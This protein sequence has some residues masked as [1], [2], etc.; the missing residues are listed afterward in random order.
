M[1]REACLKQY[2]DKI[3]V[4][5]LLKLSDRFEKK[6]QSPEQ[7][8]VSAV[9]AKITTFTHERAKVTNA[10]RSEYGLPRKESTHVIEADQTQQSQPEETTSEA[11]APELTTGDLDYWKEKLGT[12]YTAKEVISADKTDKS[13]VGGQETEI[14]R[15]TDAMQTVLDAKDQRYVDEGDDLL[16]AVA[17]LADTSKWG[18][19]TFGSK[20]E[21]DLRRIPTVV[22]EFLSDQETVARAARA[23]EL[24][25]GR[26][27]GPASKMVKMLTKADERERLL[28]EYRKKQEDKKE[29]SAKTEL[30]TLKKAAAALS[31]GKELVAE[32]YDPSAPSDY[33]LV[34]T[35]ELEI[36]DKAI[37]AMETQVR[38]AEFAQSDKA[39]DLSAGLIKLREQ[40]NAF[41]RAARIAAETRDKAEQKTQVRSNEDEAAPD[42]AAER[43]KTR[44]AALERAARRLDMGSVGVDISTSN[45]KPHHITQ[46]LEHYGIDV[47]D[48]VTPAAKKQFTT[49]LK[50]DVSTY[51]K[52][53]PEAVPFAIRSAIKAATEDKKGEVRYSKL[54]KTDAERSTVKGEATGEKASNAPVITEYPNVAGQRTTISVPGHDLE[55]Y[56]N[57]TIPQQ[58]QILAKS[59]EKTLRVLAF[60]GLNI[61]WD[62]EKATHDDVRT[63][64]KVMLTQGAVYQYEMKE[65]SAFKRGANT[66]GGYSDGHGV[67][68][69]WVDKK[70]TTADFGSRDAMYAAVDALDRDNLMTEFRLLSRNASQ[71]YFSKG[72]ATGEKA[73]AAEAEADLKDFMKSGSLGRN[74]TV[75]QDAGALPP[76]IAKSVSVD[77]TTQAFV[78][79]GHA[80]R[81][82]RFRDLANRQGTKK[83]N[84]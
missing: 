74:V 14:K 66:T 50:K 56:Y 72:Q 79:N 70:Y 41:E 73:T 37:A 69:M 82:S 10:V 47:T 20:K 64:L 71:G 51:L 38:V 67:L 12:R 36:R 33:G 53:G 16:L 6:G 27:N 80:S 29:V 7:A 76:N 4:D 77:D 44:E 78:H 52:D 65:P 30:A 49:A 9:E 26:D 55:I 28:Q 25:Y 18:E 22:R 34:A 40:R 13:R 62:A 42:M 32:D 46:L 5:G 58:E 17:Y 84:C 63:A 2:L 21:P 15:V 48:G 8:F 1:S 23:K 43:E 24:E 83:R 81:F 61:V 60:G 75:V 11:A 57:P 54:P 19:D 35:K 31:D 59:Q 68:H 3:D 39:A 45:M